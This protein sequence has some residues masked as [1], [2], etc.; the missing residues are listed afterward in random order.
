MLTSNLVRMTCFWKI[1]FG[2][3]VIDIL[4]HLINGRRELLFLCVTVELQEIDYQHFTG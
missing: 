2:W 3:S 1:K 4:G